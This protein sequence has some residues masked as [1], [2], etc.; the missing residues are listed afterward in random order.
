[1]NIDA[2]ARVAHEV[3]RAYCEALGDTSQPAWEDAPEWQRSSARMGVDLHMNGDFGPEMSHISWV[4]QKLEDGWVYG[5][6]KNAEAK[7]HPCLVPYY[8]L[9]REQQAKDYIFRAVVHALKALEAIPL[10]L[11]EQRIGVLNEQ[12]RQ[13][14]QGALL[15]IA[16]VVER[17]VGVG[18]NMTF[19]D[20]DMQRAMGLELERADPTDGGLIL[21]VLRKAAPP[22]PPQPPRLVVDNTPVLAKAEKPIV[23]LDPSGQPNQ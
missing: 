11:V 5:P 21:R 7:T 23:L 1:M 3:N 15:Y 10:S 2:I 4:K 17:A 8:Q 16:A 22:V 19:S 14:Q 20:E 12:M 13:E 6:V 9:P 18:A